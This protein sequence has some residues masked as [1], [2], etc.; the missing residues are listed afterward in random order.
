MR[1]VDASARAGITRGVRD[2][3]FQVVLGRSVTNL[4][5]LQGK[6]RQEEGVKSGMLCLVLVLFSSSRR[7][8][9]QVCLNLIGDGAVVDRSV[10]VVGGGASGKKS[11]STK[12][13]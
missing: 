7:Y 13:T 5:Q 3:F 4:M 1:A 11:P 6:K 12:S 9:R 2:V 10:V 8:D